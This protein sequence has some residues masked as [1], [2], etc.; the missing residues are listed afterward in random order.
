MRITQTPTPSNTP[1]P[2]ITA[3]QTPTVTPTG[4]LCP[5]STPSPT[6]SITPTNTPSNSALPVTPTNTPSNTPTHTPTPSITPNCYLSWQI[7]ECVDG[8]C[9][10]GFCNCNSPTQITV[11][12]NCSV[13]DITDPDTELYDTSALINP[14][15]GDFQ[16]NGDIWN[17]FGS[18]VSLVCSPGGPC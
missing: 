5:G 12:T 8:T 11:Y 4:T 13:T 17:S 2:S 6:A 18:G 3:S 15:T 16:Y 1:T 7:F 14:Y 10:G 9:S